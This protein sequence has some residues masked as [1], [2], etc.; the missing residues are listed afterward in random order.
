M[1]CPFPIP[2]N[3]ILGKFKHISDGDDP[4][5]VVH[6]PTSDVVRKRTVG[7]LD[8]GGGSLQI[9]FEITKNQQWKAIQAEPRASDLVAEFN[10]G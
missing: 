6:N 4:L 2:A 8:M 1:I 9:A 5:T 7:I 10:L 3:Y